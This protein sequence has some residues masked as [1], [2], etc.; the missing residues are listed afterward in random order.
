MNIFKWARAVPMKRR[1]FLLLLFSFVGAASCAA[2][3]HLEYERRSWPYARRTV[4]L[5]SLMGLPDVVEFWRPENYDFTRD[6]RYAAL[7]QLAA[8][9][10]KP[11]TQDPTKVYQVW[12]MLA[13]WSR[14]WPFASRASEVVVS[15][16]GFG[17]LDE[18]TTY[19]R[20][21]LNKAI[22]FDMTEDGS[23]PLRYM[24]LIGNWSFY[25]LAL[26]LVFG[27]G[28]LLVHSIIRRFYTQPG[29]CRS[30]GYNL[31]GNTSGICPEC[32]SAIPKGTRGPQATSDEQI[33]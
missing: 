24:A 3:T 8:D 16:A 10:A 14:G 29:H 30:C 4:E 23:P 11:H 2:W 31:T 22:S 25:F 27:C 20:T 13:G 9:R 6:P 19:P 17:T 7:L 1:H 32:G 15:V 26:L 33:E 21:S 28:N 12:V 18:A 5:N